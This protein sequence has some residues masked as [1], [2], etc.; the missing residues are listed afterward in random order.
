MRCA[1]IMSL[2]MIV[3]RFACIAAL[4]VSSN[5]E[6]RYASAASWRAWIA[7]DWKRTSFCSRMIQ[8]IGG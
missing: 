5:R 2:G 8:V 4:L 1:R 3:T 6:M 7:E